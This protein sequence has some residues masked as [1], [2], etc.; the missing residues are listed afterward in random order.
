MC[1]STTV[2][3]WVRAKRKFEVATTIATAGPG[4]TDHFERGGRGYV[5]VGEN[6]NDEVCVYELRTDGGRVAAE[7]V[8]C[9]K[10][11]GAGAIAV[12]EIPREDGTRE[13]DVYIVG[14]SYFDSSP[15]GDAATAPWATSSIVWRLHDGA[16]PGGK[17]QREFHFAEHQRLPG[18]GVHDAE[19]KSFAGQE[20]MNRPN[21]PLQE[22]F[23]RGIL[24][25]LRPRKT[26]A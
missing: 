3:A 23:Y 2:F 18:S 14:T 24:I 4:Q 25:F 17:N 1:E 26:T 20:A 22:K 16:A 5:V 8:Q 21:I 7:K 6:F 19:F 12:A 9:M 15:G 11:P 10:V 13:T